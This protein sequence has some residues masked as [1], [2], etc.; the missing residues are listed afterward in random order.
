MFIGVLLHW[1]ACAAAGWELLLWFSSDWILLPH[2]E[3]GV[4]A[5]PSPDVIQS[6]RSV[7]V[8]RVSSGIVSHLEVQNSF[9]CASWVNEIVNVWMT[10]PRE[11]FIAV[12][13]GFWLAGRRSR[14]WL[15]KCIQVYWLFIPVSFPSYSLPVSDATNYCTFPLKIKDPYHSYLSYHL[16]TV[17][18]YCTTCMCKYNSGFNIKIWCMHAFYAPF[19]L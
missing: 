15:M 6:G 10:S 17:T 9:S 5:E 18:S 13:S 14:C 11:R 7:S 4:R 16:I 19:T 3:H 12:H 1:K 8:R 2:N